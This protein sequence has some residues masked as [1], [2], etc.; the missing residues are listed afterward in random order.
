M[1]GWRMPDLVADQHCG[2]WVTVR[3]AT[4][5]N[6]GQVYWECRCVCG[7]VRDVLAKDL[8]SGRSRS[9]GCLQREAA[10]TCPR[11]QYQ[12]RATAAFNALCC[13]YRCNAVRRKLGWQLTH[14]ECSVLFASNCDYC[15]APPSSLKRVRGRSEFKYNG[16]D[17]VDN[18][19][20]YEIG[21][22]VPCCS[23]CN[24]AK[25]TMS[26]GEFL[27]W[28]RRVVACAGGACAW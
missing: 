24:T 4:K 7:V 10:V 28:A 18:S 2:R 20:G 21:N 13:T 3:R 17:R 1:C 26:R 9:C 6:H 12:D 16:I 25:S 23:K 22:V 11:M 14:E 8:K 5:S 19:R 27:A 15:G